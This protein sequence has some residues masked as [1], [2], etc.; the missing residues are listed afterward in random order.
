MVTLITEL[1]ELEKQFRALF[2]DES[3]KLKREKKQLQ[4]SE[5]KSVASL[6]EKYEVWIMIKI[7]DVSYLI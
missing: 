7:S 6:K 1:E 2:R 5:Q 4:L 3:K